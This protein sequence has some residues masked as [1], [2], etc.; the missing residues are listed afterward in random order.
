MF[1]ICQSSRH[2]KTHGPLVFQIFDIRA[3]W[4]ED[5]HIV[6]MSIFIIYYIF[7]FRG[8]WIWFT[9]NLSLI[10]WLSRKTLRWNTAA[11]P[12][13]TQSFLFHRWSVQR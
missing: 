11:H 7:C 8:P 3:L 2:R 10:L 13:L 1:T 5:W 4:R 9:S 6:S 12:L